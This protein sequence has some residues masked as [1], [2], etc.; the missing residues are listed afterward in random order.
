MTTLQ[1]LQFDF[2]NTQS[3]I[4]ELTVLKLTTVSYF[5]ANLIKNIK[6]LENKLAEISRTYIFSSCGKKTWIR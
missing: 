1:Q 3:R 5:Q 6:E 4:E 2:N